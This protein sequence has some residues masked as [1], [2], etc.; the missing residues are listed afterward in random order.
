MTSRI[1][2]KTGQWQRQKGAYLS[3]IEKDLGLWPKCY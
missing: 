2:R 3:I 1:K